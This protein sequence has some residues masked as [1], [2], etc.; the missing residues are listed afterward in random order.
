[1]HGLGEFA[2]RGRLLPQHHDPVSF[3]YDINRIA[4]TS[5]DRIDV[6]LIAKIVRDGVGQD[7]HHRIGAQPLGNPRNV[8]LPR[9]SLRRRQCQ[10][11]PRIAPSSGQAQ[12]KGPRTTSA[13]ARVAVDGTAS[14]VSGSATTTL[15]HAHTDEGL[16][17]IPRPHTD[18]TEDVHGNLKQD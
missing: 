10:L 7:A 16:P 13:R 12:K 11:Y 3:A 18:R 15:T 8:G 9:Q 6:R 2:R 5:Q 14:H 17:H 4:K 1:M